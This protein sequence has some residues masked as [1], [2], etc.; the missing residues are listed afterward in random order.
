MSDLSEPLLRET[1]VDSAD[2]T[3]E[4]PKAEEERFHREEEE[5]ESGSESNDHTSIS[6]KRLL[7]LS[8]LI[9]ATCVTCGIS[10][11]FYIYDSLLVH[12]PLSLITAAASLPLIA[13]ALGFPFVARRLLRLRNEGGGIQLETRRLNRGKAM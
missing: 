7:L 4:E 9:F 6:L 11:D 13:V 5:E 8:L 12:T 3:Q 1:A 10:A 2:F